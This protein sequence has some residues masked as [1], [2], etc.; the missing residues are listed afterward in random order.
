MFGA[1]GKR[2]RA[3][4]LRNGSRTVSYTHLDVYKR[5]ILHHVIDRYDSE[6]DLFALPEDMRS[7]G[8]YILIGPYRKEYMDDF[9]LNRLIQKCGLPISLTS[10]LRDYFCEVPIVMDSGS[11]DELLLSI[12]RM[13]YDDQEIKKRLVELKEDESMGWKEDLPEDTL[14]HTKMLEDRYRME[15]ELLHAIASGDADTCL[16]YTSRC[17]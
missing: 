9:R 15:N 14:V 13:C 2:R 10:G 6:Y 8:D 16:L 11:W 12:V 5:Q 1:N 3:R 4:E 7:C 17:V